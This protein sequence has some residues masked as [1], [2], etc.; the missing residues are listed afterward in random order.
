MFPKAFGNNGNYLQCI[1]EIKLFTVHS[2]HAHNIISDNDCQCYSHMETKPEK[3]LEF[4]TNFER[5]KK[6]KTVKLVVHGY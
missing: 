5:F 3:A 2:L 6:M 4:L 1:S